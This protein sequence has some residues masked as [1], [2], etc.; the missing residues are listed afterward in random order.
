M[1]PEW[2]TDKHPPHSPFNKGELNS[3]LERGD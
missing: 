2:T 3:P 1:M